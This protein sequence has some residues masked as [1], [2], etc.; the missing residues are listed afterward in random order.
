M[1]GWVGD[2]WAE[3]WVVMGAGVGGGETAARSVGETT[4]WPTASQ[5]ARLADGMVDE[6]ADDRAG[7]MVVMRLGSRAAWMA[8][9]VAGEVSGRVAAAW[10]CWAGG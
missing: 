9:G 4:G 6:I 1:V 2:C 7:R 10:G 3:R 5:G 8:V